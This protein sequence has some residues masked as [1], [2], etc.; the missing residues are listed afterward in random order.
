MKNPNVYLSGPMD[1]VSDGEGRGWREEAKELLQEHGVRVFDPYDF[2]EN[3]NDPKQLVK[4]DLIHIAQSHG[5]LINASQNA[6]V[7][8]SPMEVIISWR[9]GLINVAFT[10][11]RRV[12][13]WLSAHSTITTTLENAVDNIT[14]QLSR[15]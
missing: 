7:W 10:G 11:D 8:G 14:W 13:P 4:T 5:M 6:V 2:E 12:S 9:S 15:L 1:D 3:V